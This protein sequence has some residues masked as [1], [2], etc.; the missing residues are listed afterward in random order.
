MNE[1]TPGFQGEDTG[2]AAMCPAAV[3]DVLIW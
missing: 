3:G 1:T 2:H